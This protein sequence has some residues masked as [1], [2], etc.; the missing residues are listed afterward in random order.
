M[1][2]A[3]R[4]NIAHQ[5]VHQDASPA[6]S[7]WGPGIVYSRLLRFQSGAELDLPS[8]AVECE[9]CE[10]WG[11]SEAGTEFMFRLRNVSHAA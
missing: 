2:L 3:T 11:M 7:T 9:L 1:N 10:G 8:L 6:L 4:E 5:D